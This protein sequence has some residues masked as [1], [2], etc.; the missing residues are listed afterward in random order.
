MNQERQYR[1]VQGGG[2]DNP[3]WE[4]QKNEMNNTYPKELSGYLKDTREIQGQNGAFMVAE[5]QMINQDG[6]PGNIVD[7]SGGKV[8]DDAIQKVDIGS[9]IMIRYEG[10]VKSKIGGRTYNSWAIFVDDNAVPL[11]QLGGVDQGK[12]AQ[13]KTIPPVNNTPETNNGPFSKTSSQDKPAVQQQNW[14]PPAKNQGAV[15]QPVKQPVKQ[16]NPFANN[17]DDLPF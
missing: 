10:K 4:P 2:S 5:I 11:Q 12:M 8:L 1:Q 17:N 13:P 14:T 15:N 3:R 6:S 7:V 9:F 16:D